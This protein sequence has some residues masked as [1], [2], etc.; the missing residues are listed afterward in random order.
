MDEVS[1]CGPTSVA[2]LGGGA[3]TR[4]EITPEELGVEPVDP[5][6]LAGGEP[7]ENA[8][9]V[10]A[11]VEGREPGAARAAVLVNAAAAFYV[12]DRAETL[13]EGVAAAERAIDSGA[14]A[15]V[16]EELVK[17]SQR[18]AATR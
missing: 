10:R 7:E 5:G 17:G 3:V 6:A 13:R 4:Y 9:V 2:E 18:A 8:A 16:L 1:P 12:A 14:A 15:G 11:V